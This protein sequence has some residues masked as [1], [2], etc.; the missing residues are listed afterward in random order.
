MTPLEKSDAQF[1]VVEA[2]CRHT[3]KLAKQLADERDQLK[4]Q[5]AEANLKLDDYRNRFDV[6]ASQEKCAK[7]GHYNSPSL[8]ESGWCLSCICDEKNRQLTIALEALAGIPRCVPAMEGGSLYREHFDGE[9]NYIWRENID[10]LSVIQEMEKIA[11]EALAA[12][13][14]Q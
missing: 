12:M 13:K 3:L 8:I 7:C 4:A 2:M 9:G 10:P 14:G 11:N 1:R 6:E 5:L